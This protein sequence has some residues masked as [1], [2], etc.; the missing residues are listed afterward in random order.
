MV[1]DVDQGAMD[2]HVDEDKNA[3][4]TGPVYKAFKVLYFGHQ[5]AFLP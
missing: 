3:C 4:R 1:E 2:T 5:G